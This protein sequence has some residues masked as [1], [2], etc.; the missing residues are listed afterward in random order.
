MFKKG[1]YNVIYI[2]HRCLCR[3]V[4][5][6]FLLEGWIVW[7]LRRVFDD[8]LVKSTA[9]LT[10]IIVACIN[11]GK[12]EISLQLLRNMLETDVVPDNYVI[13]SILGACSSLEYIKVGKEIH[14]YVLRRGTEMDVTVSNVLFD[15]YMKCGKVK[16]ARSDFD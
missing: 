11:V 15:F 14:C 12:S 6:R 5:D 2:I 10:A 7:S 8:L 13:S 16:T 9:T 3:D 1:I 4:F